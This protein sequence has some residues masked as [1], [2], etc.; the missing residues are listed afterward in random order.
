MTIQANAD[1]VQDKINE[2]DVVLFA[3]MSGQ[4]VA[5]AEAFR[6]IMNG[7]DHGASLTAIATLSSIAHAVWADDLITEKAKEEAQRISSARTAAREIAETVADSAFRHDGNI[8]EDVTK[9][10]EAYCKPV[11]SLATALG[12]LGTLGKGKPDVS[13]RDKTILVEHFVKMFHYAL[14]DELKGRGLI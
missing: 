6:S 4:D 14:S 7:N 12:T 9:A 1:K 2:S 8:D 3:R 10:F 11:R 13:K 5:T